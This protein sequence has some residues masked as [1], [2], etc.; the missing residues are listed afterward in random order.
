M[1][2]NSLNAPKD[3]YSVGQDVVHLPSRGLWYAHKKSEVMVEYMTAI[4][5]NILTA[6]N[7]IKTERQFDELLKRKIKDPDIK[8]EE[9]LR[10]DKNAILLNLRVNGYG[11]DYNVKVTDPVTRET[12]PALVDLLLLENKPLLHAPDDDLLFTFTLPVT[13]KVVRFRLLTDKEQKALE[14]SIEAKAK[15][16]TTVG[17]VTERLKAQIV[18]VDGSDN[19]MQISNFVDRMPVKDSLS[20]RIFMNEVEPDLDLTYEFTNPSTGDRFSSYVS[21]DLD[22]FY[23]NIGI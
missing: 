3:D 21:F 14:K 20:L 18:Y 15:V 23:P 6:P 11:A 1:L 10:G 19:K 9:L 4:D 5:E 13:K 17:S 16:M 2:E 12:F 22:L 7:L 8:V